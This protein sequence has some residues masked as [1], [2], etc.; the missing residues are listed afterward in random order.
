[1][2]EYRVVC[3]IDTEHVYSGEHYHYEA[4]SCHWDGRH[5]HRRTFDKAQAEKYLAEAKE[6]CPVYDEITQNRSGIHHI[7]YKQSNIRIETREVTE[8]K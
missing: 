5:H 6:K 4:A 3:T 2:T 8:W 1:M 7:K